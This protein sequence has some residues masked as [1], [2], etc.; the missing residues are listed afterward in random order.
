MPGPEY[1]GAADGAGSLREPASSSP[2]FVDSSGRRRKTWRRLTIAVVAAL[3]GYTGLLA[4]GFAGGPIPPAALLPIP[5]VPGNGP[6]TTAPPAGKAS[7]PSAPSEAAH[8]A[9]SKTGER[10][11]GFFGQTG[12]S[13]AGVPTTGASGSIGSTTSQPSGA[14]PSGTA[15]PTTPS[16]TTGVNPSS[17][18][19]STTHGRQTTPPSHSHSK[20]P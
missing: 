1:S 17:A 16:G 19:S 4:V 12:P 5:G 15:V 11:A 10:T 20:T 2:V 14:N 8:A 13:H 6:A 18:V 7:D 9:T 3:C